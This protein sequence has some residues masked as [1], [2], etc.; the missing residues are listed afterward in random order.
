MWVDAPSLECL[1]GGAPIG[2][3]APCRAVA[4]K[5]AACAACS[6]LLNCIKA[7]LS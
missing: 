7:L 4:A 5:S 3:E 6:C 1:F 2:C